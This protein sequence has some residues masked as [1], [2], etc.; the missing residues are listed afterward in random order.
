[1]STR[2]RSEVR[3]EAIL[4]AAMNLLSEV[5]YDQMTIDAVAER[6][7]ASKATIYR[8]WSGKADLVT[9]AVRRYA[10]TPVTTPSE[11]TSLR[12]DLVAVLQ[13]LRASLTG[14]DAALILGLLVAMRRDPDLADTVRRHVLDHKREVFAA[15]LTRAVARGDL[16]ATADH[17]LLAEIS[18]AAL[19][20]R[21]LITGEPL[22]DQFLRK[23]V[24]AVL[25]PLLNHQP[26]QR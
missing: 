6:A 12:D 20:S 24:D 16:P 25:L 13:S 4:H 26:H 23:L 5:G 17:T 7:R 14:Q 22:D 21:L 10:G 15:V 1:M 2:R 3:E 11:T 8:R 9:T 19:F 18:S